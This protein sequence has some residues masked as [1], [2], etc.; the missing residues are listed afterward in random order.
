VS[1]EEGPR[2]EVRIDEILFAEDLARCTQAARAAIEPT[3]ASLQDVGLPVKWLRRCEGEGRDGTRLGGCVKFYIPQPAG[4]WARF[5]RLMK[6]L[7]SP[8]WYCSPWVSAIPIDLGARACMRSLTADTTAESDPRRDM[9]VIL[10]VRN[11]AL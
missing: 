7:K 5:S 4:R 3:V 9:R 8:L 11:S 6:E 2:F 10:L 1:A